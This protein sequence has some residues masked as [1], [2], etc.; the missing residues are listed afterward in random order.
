MGISDND[1]GPTAL[2]NVS[3][4]EPGQGVEKCIKVTYGGSLAGEVRM[5]TDSSIG[6]LGS[7]VN[8]QI[9][10]GHPDRLA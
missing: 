4:L 2:Y 10:P 5:Y 7:Q 1:G 3:G 9:T 8:V 6:A